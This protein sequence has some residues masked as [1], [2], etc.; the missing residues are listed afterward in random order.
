MKKY[1][2]LP[3]A[4]AG[5]AVAAVLV[6]CFANA[7][8]DRPARPP[9]D[10]QPPAGAPPREG[11]PRDQERPDPL[12]QLFDAD[13]DRQLSFDEID[14][15]PSK[16]KQ[17]DLDSDGYLVR[18]E[19]P[20]PP[21]P[22]E[23]QEEANMPRP[24]RPPRD[25]ARTNDPH[26]VDTSRLEKGTVVFQGGYQTDPRDGGR[27]I[28]LI[29]AALGVKDQLFRDAFSNVRPARDGQ[30]TP[31]RV[32]ENKAVLMAALGK[33][34]VSND[35]LDEVSNY[36]R[37]RPQE[38]ELWTHRP[39]RAEAVIVDG[40]VTEIKLLDA[41]AGYSSMPRIEVV[42]YPDA[43]VSAMVEYGIDLITNGKIGSLTLNP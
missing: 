10:G 30:P 2:S 28:V 22:D 3:S 1:F 17:A 39:A 21:R 13:G 18:E 12:L 7:Q 31:E 32:R 9:R 23:S 40:K 4:L 35:R 34:G 42:G 8:S 29:A 20:R 5:F 24:P 41:G 38:G 15:I 16:L 25:Q 43:K 19:L 6:G 26:V 11:A 33:H 14:A 37:Y 36:Y 27:P